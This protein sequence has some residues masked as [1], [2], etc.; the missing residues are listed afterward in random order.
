MTKPDP[1]ARVPEAIGQ[2]VMSD[3]KSAID[4][5]HLWACD[6][7]PGRL[8]EPLGHCDGV[9]RRQTRDVYAHACNI[10]AWQQLYDQLDP[11]SFRGELTEVWLDGLQFFREYTS[12]ALHQSCMVWPGAF[13]FGIPYGDK[14]VGY[15][16]RDCI[17]AQAIAVRP[18]GRE[19]ELSTPDDYNILGLVV[20]R[21]ALLEHLELEELRHLGLLLEE[22]RLLQ[23]EPGARR[24]LCDFMRAALALAQV[25]PLSLREPAV[26]RQLNHDLLLCLLDLLQGAEPARDACSRTLLRK[27]WV[28]AQARE[29]VLD[30]PSRPVSALELCR[31]LHVSQ[32]TLRNCFLDVLGR[33]PIHYLK[34]VRL[35]AVHR[36]LGS[37]HSP[38]A[39]VQDAAMAWGFWHMGQ[40]GRDYQQL[41]GERPSATLA[42]R[43]RLSAAW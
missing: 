1:L 10:T 20:E 9:R 32:R 12:H 15:I 3:K 27:H 34:A 4:L 23:V 26:A 36:E 11:G 16:G 25:E 13:W 17:D 8:D 29:Y 41:F 18:G 19:F 31:L 37:P 43:E 2:G 42:N 28:V 21:E 22:S 24:R 30:N 35:N 38:Y 39:T 40:F 33:S 6:D 7:T 14:D 5:H